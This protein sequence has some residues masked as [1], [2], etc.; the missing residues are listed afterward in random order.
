MLSCWSLRISSRGPIP[1]ILRIASYCAFG[2]SVAHLCVTF[3]NLWPLADY[4]VQ[5]VEGHQGL[6]VPIIPLHSTWGDVILTGMV[7]MFFVT[8]P[9]KLRPSIIRV[10]YMISLSYGDYTRCGM[11]G[12]SYV[13][14]RHC[15]GWA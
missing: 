7:I 5:I 10:P 15:Y 9:R 1:Q 12:I 2:F 8:V 3:K 4:L 13:F 11:S 6:K 14:R